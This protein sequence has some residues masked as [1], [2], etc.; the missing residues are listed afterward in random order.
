MAESHLRY[1]P[2]QKTA[3]P[4]RSYAMKY[5]V[6]AATAAAVVIAGCTSSPGRAG[7][8]ANPASRG[9]EPNSGPGSGSATPR[10]TLRLGYLGDVTQAAALVGIREG[11]FADSLGRGVAIRPVLFATAGA[12][13]AALASGKLDAAYASPATILAV[14]AIRHAS[15][16]VVISGAS[17]ASAELVISRRL[18]GLSALRG[19][20]LAIPAAGDAQ[21]IA[22]RHWLASRHLGVGSHAGVAVTAIAQG[23]A[24]IAAFRAGKI[25]G[26]LEPAPVDLELAA[27]GGRVL[28]GGSGPSGAAAATANLVVTR[29]FLDANSAAVYG[30]LRGQVQANDFVRHNLLQSSQAIG[31][32][33][34]AA[35]HPVPQRF[36]ALSLA[37]ITFTDDP[38]AASLIAQARQAA[39]DGLAAPMAIPPG[40]YD[41]APLD[42]VLR[43][44]GEPPVTN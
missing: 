39:A 28:A 22:L 26:A 21:D 34:A 5:L 19:H 13:A 9:S 41:I 27:A 3:A 12:E 42:L 16:I 23:P 2:T 33:L 8:G 14:L 6:A 25:A 31:T 40:L 20:T 29:K 17:A 32:G 10:Q 11:L 1:V 24:V 18:G 44:A 35:G 4:D 15:G 30:L 7:P 43:A 38:L 37:Q 36:L